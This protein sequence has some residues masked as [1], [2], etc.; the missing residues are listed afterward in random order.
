MRSAARQFL[1]LM[2]A[3]LALGGLERLLGAA[4][5]GGEDR[6]LRAAAG[7]IVPGKP[8][9]FATTMTLG[10]VGRRPAGRKPHGPA[11]QDRR[12]SRSSGQPRA[13]D[14]SSG[15]GPDAVRSRPLADGDA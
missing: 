5:A 3:S 6:A 11:D 8:L 4:G 2:G 1:T 14:L 13:T 12:Q 9:F 15:V 10:G 7:E